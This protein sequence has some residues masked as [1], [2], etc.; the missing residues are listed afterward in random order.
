MLTIQI[1][2]EALARQ[3]QA[4][5]QREQRPVEAVLKSMVEAQYPP[6]RAATDSPLPAESDP[7]R[8]VRRKVYAKAR[9]YWEK[10]GALDKVQLTDEE[11]D[12]QFGAFDEE[13]IPRLKSELKSLQP[14]IGSLAYAALIA[15]RGNLRSGKPDL[16]E[17]SRDILDQHFANDFSRRMQGED[18]TE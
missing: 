7:V 9:L 12:A 2:D 6:E 8:R 13:G 16:A 10:V 17:Q 18:G 3:L 11:L 5:A 1:Q 14:P 15:E 4:I